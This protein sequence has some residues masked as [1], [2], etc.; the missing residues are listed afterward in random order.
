MY[1][2]SHSTY[3]QLASELTERLTSFT[4]FNG[5][6]E[7]NVENI[8]FRFTATLLIY[9][10]DESLPEGDISIIDNIVPVW[11]EM[12]T[13]TLFGE[14]NNDFDFNIFKEYICQ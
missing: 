12:H 8:E 6:I 13:T 7:F 4:L 14:I 9:L 1:K 2:F 3:T 5:T 11:W 10:R